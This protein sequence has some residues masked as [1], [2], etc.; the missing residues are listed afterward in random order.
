MLGAVKFAADPE[1]ASWL[2][3]FVASGGEFQWDAGNETKSALKHGVTRDDVEV[4]VRDGAII[5]AG[6]IVEP[7]HEE[8]RWLLL[9]ETP[10]GKLVSVVFTRRGEKGHLLRPISSRPMAKKERKFYGDATHEAEDGEGEG[11]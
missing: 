9:G 2:A 6:R 11:A 10:A 5:L 4:L 7:A 1:T 8:P 3:H